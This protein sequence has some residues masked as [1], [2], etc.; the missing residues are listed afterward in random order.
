MRRGALNLG[1]K[2]TIQ[3]KA[4]H[5]AAFFLYSGFEHFAALAPDGQ[6]E[7]IDDDLALGNGEAI[8]KIIADLADKGFL[9]V[10]GIAVDEVQF[11]ICT[12]GGTVAVPEAVSA[13]NL[14][15]GRL[16]GQGSAGNG[17]DILVQ[18]GFFFG[19]QRTG[20]ADVEIWH[21]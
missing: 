5:W 19:S 20:K 9:L 10:E 7:N 18:L 17:I 3:K 6:D 1:T 16:I 14:H 2:T 12:L 4:A 8:G 11:D 13:R 15:H 21:R